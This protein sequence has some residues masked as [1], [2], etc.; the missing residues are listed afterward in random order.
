MKASFVTLGCKVNQYET[1]ALKEL[2][3][4]EGYEIVSE[5]DPADVCVVNTCSVT[6]I[7]DRKS[8]QAVRH[9]K[10]LNP[11]C[12][13]VV[14]GCYAQTGNEA[15]RAM[16]EVDIVAGTNEKS[17]IPELVREYIEDQEKKFRVLEYEKLGCFDEM[18]IVEAMEGRTRAYIKIQEGCNR[19]CS[20]CIIPY[21][22]GNV[23][24]R[25][26]EDI[27]KEAELL[28]NCGYKELVLTGIN[29]ALYGSEE[30]GEPKLHILIDKIS[31]IEGDY[32]IR[33]SSLEP[34]VINAEYIKKLFE[35]KKLCHHVHLS[36]QSGSDNVL[37][38]MKRRYDMTE[39]RNIVKTIKD[40]DE[41][42]GITTDIIVGFP[43]EE[44]EDFN[45]SVRTVEDIDF[46]KVH[47]FK[48][49][50]RGG[51]PADKM[52]DQVAPQVKNARSEALIKASETS[53]ERFIN[54][55]LGTSRSVLFEEYDRKKGTI[56]GLADNYI[57]VYVKMD[58][59][60]AENAINSFGNVLLEQRFL[61]G[62]KGILL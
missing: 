9:L 45:D 43:G 26:E 49:S 29:T 61:D 3:R 41:N 62:I 15:V 44:E 28:I 60:D 4:A 14:T 16:E 18:G 52:K 23:R 37:K 40:F 42:Y 51:T 47:V 34:T 25:N 11:D 24:S 22:R 31:R 38:S 58:E 8:R 6:N 12:I 20:Y 7:A 56:T 36:V 53:A 13:V 54:K 27:L 30:D 35:F 10:K 59:K 2:F 50:R 48:Y 32:R 57:R 17:S 33:L 5:N 19:F 46:C 55:N 1:Q 39:Y 21:A